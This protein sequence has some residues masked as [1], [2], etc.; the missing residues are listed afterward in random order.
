MSKTEIV[1][2]DGTRVFQPAAVEDFRMLARLDMPTGAVVTVGQHT[3]RELAGFVDALVSIIDRLEQQ[4][5]ANQWLEDRTAER[6]A[7]TDAAT[8]RDAARWRAVRDTIESTRDGGRNDEAALRL[9]AL[10]TK[11]LVPAALDAEADRIMRERAAST[12]RP[13]FRHGPAIR[14]PEWLPDKLEAASAAQRRENVRLTAAMRAFR[15]AWEHFADVAHHAADTVRPLADVIA[16][17]WL[18]Y[19]D[20][21]E[22]AW[23]IIANVSGSDWTLQGTEWQIAAQQWRDDYN[24]MLEHTNKM[25]TFEQARRYRAL[26]H[27]IESHAGVFVVPIESPAGTDGMRRHLLTGQALDDFADDVDRGG[28]PRAIPS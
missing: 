10:L 3:A 16:A 7:A 2:Q 17:P 25:P 28:A 27:Y 6:D 15:D 9:A 4:A 13:R 19:E 26:R 12:P 20:L 23:G 21:I 11:S 5:K 22:A 24:V 8:D 1:M 18:D 14:K